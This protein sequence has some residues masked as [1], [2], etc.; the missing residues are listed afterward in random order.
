MKYPKFLSRLK[1][2]K[3]LYNFQRNPLRP[4]SPV[5]FCPIHTQHFLPHPVLQWLP[6]SVQPFPLLPPIQRQATHSSPSMGTPRTSGGDNHCSPCTARIMV[7][8]RLTPEV[9]Q[10][11]LP[12]PLDHD[13]NC[14]LWMYPERI[15]C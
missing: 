11:I 1:S 5:D 2:L 13:S 6:V 4:I 3:A 10:G 9:T 7:F 12:L 8:I 15:L 14:C